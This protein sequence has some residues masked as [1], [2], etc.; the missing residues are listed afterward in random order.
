MSKE[1]KKDRFYRVA[2]ARTNKIISMLRL[3]GNCSNRF[4]YDY[5]MEQVE[6]IFTAIQ[7]E[8]EKAKKRF[9]SFN[10]TRKKRFSLSEPSETEPEEAI[11]ML[12]LPLP[13]GTALLAEV[14][15]SDEYPMICIC[16]ESYR[17]RSPE[18]LCMAEYDPDR[19]PCHKVCVAAYRAHEEEAVFYKPYIMEEKEE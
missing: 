18:L 11:P 5:H 14:H 1:S 13:D 3:L 12:R 6:Q 16:W 10:G 9:L 17:K 15:E 2:E 8:M 4:V 7:V 19:S